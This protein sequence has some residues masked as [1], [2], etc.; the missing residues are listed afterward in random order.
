[1]PFDL[2][3]AKKA[4]KKSKRRPAKKERPSIKEKTEMLYEKVLVLFLVNRLSN[5]PSRHSLI[6]SFIHK[7]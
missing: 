7:N 2:N 3:A 1:M 5:H 4:G 6:R